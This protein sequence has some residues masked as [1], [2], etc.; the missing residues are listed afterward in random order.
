[1]YNDYAKIVS[2][3]KHK[4]KY[5]E[6]L[7]ILTPKYVLHRLQTALAQVKAGNNSEILLNEVRQIVSSLYQSKEI[8]KKIYNNKIKSI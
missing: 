2:E 7:K 8:T 3:A 5:G 6:G 1:M 4:P